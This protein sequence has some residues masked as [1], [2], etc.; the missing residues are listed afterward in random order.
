MLRRLVEGRGSLSRGFNQLRCL[1]A[2]D[3]MDGSPTRTLFLYICCHAF[4]DFA[5]LLLLLLS[6]RLRT[7]LRS[8]LT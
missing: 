1:R 3:L 7:Y 4:F 5:M 2:H 8:H 6:W